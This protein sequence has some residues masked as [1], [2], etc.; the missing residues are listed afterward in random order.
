MR[1]EPDSPVIGVPPVDIKYHS[2]VFAELP[3]PTTEAVGTP[4]PHCI[5]FVATGA[6][7]AGL[8]VTIA[9]EAVDVQPVIGSV[10]V[11][12]YTCDIGVPVLFTITTEV[13]AVFKPVPGDQFQVIT[14]EIFVVAV[15]LNVNLGRVEYVPLP[16]A[17]L[18]I[19][20]GV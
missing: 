11:T 12:L 7:S 4:S 20:A 16:V 15:A 5:E 19:A 17:A 2:N 13:S 14:F 8:I 1:V 3:L 10:K 18:R 9:V 6:N